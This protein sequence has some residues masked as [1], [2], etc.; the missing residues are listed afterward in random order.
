MTQLHL[1]KQRGHPTS[2]GYYFSTPHANS[3]TSICSYLNSIQN[4]ILY[5]LETKTQPQSHS[6]HGCPGRSLPQV[7]CKLHKLQLRKQKLTALRSS[8]AMMSLLFST[9]ARS[10]VCKYAVASELTTTDIVF[11][12]YRLRHSCHQRTYQCLHFHALQA[13]N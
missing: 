5:P 3:T 12:W 2:L 11:P 1:R 10:A 13:I 7:W 8:S 6:N 4:L 9:T